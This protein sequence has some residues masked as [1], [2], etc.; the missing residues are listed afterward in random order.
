M[1]MCISEHLEENKKKAGEIFPLA[2]SFDLITR[3]LL[4]GKKE[5]FFI[6]VNG[7]CKAEILQQIFADLQDPLFMEDADLHKIESYVNG[8]IGYIQASLTDSWDEIVKNVLS[9][10]A[11]LFLDGFAQAILLDVRSYPTRGISEPDTERVIKGARD[12]FVETLLFNANLIRRRIRSPRLTF[13]ILSIGTESK[14]DVAVAYLKGLADDALLKQ[15]KNKLSSLQVSSLTMGTKSLEEL[16]VPRKWFHPL[17]ST[18]LTER[19]DVAASF[20][21]EGHIVVL[22]DNSPSV[23]ILPCTIFQFTQSAEDYYK[24]PVVG[25]YFRLVRFLCIPASL[26]LLPVFILLTAYYPQLSEKWNLLSTSQDLSPGILI[27]YVFAVEFILDLF[28]YSA[29]LSSSRF[30][31]SL[32][33]VGGLIL[34][35]IA[36]ELNWASTEILFYAAITLLSSLALSSMEFADGLRVYR[37]FLILLTAIFGT[38]GFAAGLFLILLSVATTPTFGNMSYFWPLIPF[39]KDALK[40]L[41]FRYPTAKAQPS[42]IWHRK[43]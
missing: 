41:L 33:I 7:F 28:K 27:F 36:V 14:T 1:S 20:L 22:T 24:S 37:I 12:G 3:S 29:S 16:L 6:G 4:F 26:L 42:K 35:D 31:G 2:Q 5:G 17:P 15:L 23:M 32:S 11:V 34:G 13:E 43:R 18:H 30:S 38:R 21:E 8:K 9:G 10:P 40:T 19:P 25:T 39:N